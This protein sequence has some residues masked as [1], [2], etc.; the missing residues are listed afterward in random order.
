MECFSRCPATPPTVLQ[1]YGSSLHSLD[2]HVR[3][4]LLNDVH[5]RRRF[6]LA[7]YL[8]ITPAVCLG[9]LSCWK[10]KFFFPNESL[11]N[12][13]GVVDEYL[14]VFGCCKV[15]GDLAQMPDSVVCD[16]APNL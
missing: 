9:S 3:P 15:I 2:L 11:P 1:V 7:R 10:T 16:R 4:H 8:L 5:V 14:L 12:R 6:L 13:H